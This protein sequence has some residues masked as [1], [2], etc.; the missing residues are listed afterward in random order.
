M[1]M[2]KMLHRVGYRDACQLMSGKFVVWEDHWN[3][4]GVGHCK[5]CERIAKLREQEAR[6]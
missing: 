3:F 6:T 2:G 1:S 5:R 4:G